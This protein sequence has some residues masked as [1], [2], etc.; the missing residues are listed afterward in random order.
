MPLRRS[1]A[2]GRRRRR[3]STTPAASCSASRSTTTDTKLSE[4]HRLMDVPLADA[5]D[6]LPEV[7]QP[8]LRVPL[9]DGAPLRCSTRWAGSTSGSI[10]RE[11]MDFAMRA[12]VLG[13]AVTFAEDAVVTYMARD[14]FDADRPPLPPLPLV[15]P[16]RG[17][18]A[19][20]VRVDVGCDARSRHVSG[21]SGRRGTG[22]ALPRRPI[23]AERQ[24]PR[25]SSGS[26]RWVVDRL[27][28]QVVD[29]QTRT[30]G[31]LT[32]RPCRRRSIPQRVSQVDPE[33]R[34]P[35]PANQRRA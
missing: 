22:C 17:R 7:A 10:T 35:R 18:V 28:A 23:P 13:R 20:C 34:E 8:R 14:A 21:T 26:A 33:L 16:S 11:Q 3:S 32:I 30:R 31:D 29:E 5:E 19:R 6:A 12:L 1:S 15:R 9:H 27:E 25:R 24:H 4:T 2:S